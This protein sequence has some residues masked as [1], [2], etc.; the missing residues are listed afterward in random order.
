MHSR[1]YDCGADA[2]ACVEGSCES[3]L[4][5]GDIQHTATAGTF[6][7]RPRL[8]LAQVAEAVSVD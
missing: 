6:R 2:V 1:I 4:P 7:L 3:A 8:T 5:S